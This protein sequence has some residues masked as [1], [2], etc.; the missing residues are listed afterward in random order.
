MSVA[1]TNVAE[2]A[3]NVGKAAEGHWKNFMGLFKKKEEEKAP[4]LEEP[5]KK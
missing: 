3:K 5:E 1:S 2:G 4:V